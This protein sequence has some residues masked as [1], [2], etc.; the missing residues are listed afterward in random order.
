MG[1]LHRGFV[2]L[3]KVLIIRSVKKIRVLFTHTFLL[4]SFI[5][6]PG[7]AVHWNAVH[8]T[9]FHGVNNEYACAA[10]GRWEVYQMPAHCY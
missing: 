3:R 8:D 1:R 10:I 6:T 4:K 5:M 9:S 7:R 2:F